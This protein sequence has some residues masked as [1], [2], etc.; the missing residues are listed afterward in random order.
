MRSEEIEIYVHKLLELKKYKTTDEIDLNTETLDFKTK[1]PDLYK[2]VLSN[3]MDI[4][5]FNKMMI[6]KRKLENGDDPY[7][8]DVKFGEIMAERYVYPL[9]NKK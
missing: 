8:V 9:I 4:E 3:E 5:I 2:I 1:Y 6:C 7:S